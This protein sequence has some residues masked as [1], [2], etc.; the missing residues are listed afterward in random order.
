MTASG[1]PT[2][3]VHA[4]VATTAARATMGDKRTDAGHPSFDAELTQAQH[5]A[6][7]STPTAASQRHADQ[8]P[9]Q[10]QRGNTPR[11]EWD[12]PQHPTLRGKGSS[13]AGRVTSAAARKPVLPH[14]LATG[15]QTTTDQTA[16]A[17][18]Q[19]HAVTPLPT[20]VGKGSAPAAGS[21]PSSA[22]AEPTAATPPTASAD[23]PA[24]PATPALVAGHPSTDAAT[25]AGPLQGAAAPTS[26]AAPVAPGTAPSPDGQAQGPVQVAVT[27][28]PVPAPVPAQP[29]PL[30]TPP[31]QSRPDP[32][33]AAQT[34]ASTSA[35][36]PPPNQH[37]GA[38]ATA[39]P[40][41]AQAGTEPAAVTVTATSDREATD[42]G[43]AQQGHDQAPASHGH[44]SVEGTSSGGPV[45]PC[46]TVTDRTS[47]TSAAAVAPQ[48]EARTAAETPAT[49][50]LP[51]GTLAQ[52]AGADHSVR[53]Q[54][55]TL[56]LGKVTADMHSRPGEIGVHLSVPDDAGRALMAQ[57]L[58][59][60][61]DSLGQGGTA[62]H[63]SLAAQGNDFQGQQSTTPRE[64][65]A[66]AP[67]APQPHDAA[68]P[69][70]MDGSPAT[71][72]RPAPAD[73]SRLVDVHA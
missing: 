8:H 19:P 20:S 60:L 21:G 23:A 34:S 46:S 2:S 27:G 44:A 12:V 24:A 66:P 43:A 54:L 72:L 30:P 35:V 64:D 25:P 16:A 18:L 6:H 45:T 9:Q 68:T 41:P 10:D 11:H 26:L 52:V 15:D 67:S 7:A 62:V 28:Q 31:L 17:A 33:A 50:A 59:A 56:A 4:L 42:Q 40:A 63:L 3:A 48:A 70:A 53:V 32:S 49:Q 65:S 1:G 13:S 61:R 37:H 29:L 58:D 71:Q 73:G 22:A 14:P 36:A 55:E 38:A 5:P 57:R 47:A 39:V 51:A 69:R